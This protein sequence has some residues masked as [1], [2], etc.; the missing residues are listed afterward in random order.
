MIPLLNL[1]RLHAP[2]RDDFQRVFDELLE[3][4]RFI[5][6]R[7][8][9]AFCAAFAAWQNIPHCIGCANGTEALRIAISAA[10]GQG[11]GSREIITVSHTFIA[12]AESILASGYRPVFVDIE[13]TT[14]LMNLDRLPPLITEST[15][16]IV[17]VHLYGQ[18]VDMKRLSAIA[19]THHIALIEDAAQAHGASRDGV[20]PGQ[21]SA[22][23]GY[24]FFPGKNLGAFGDAGAVVTGV[25]PVAE[26]ARLAVD[27]GRPD[28]RDG[29]G[30]NEHRVFSG[31]SRLDALFAVHAYFAPT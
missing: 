24:S 20:E 19:R 25:D 3:S 14:G 12:T 1:T 13:P 29:G 27:H 31:N 9:D 16:A 5:D 22:A 21:L 6:A 8:V 28:R 15:A 10:I 2:L 30:K 18:M 17:P 23:A 7:A 4:S 26:A 11:D